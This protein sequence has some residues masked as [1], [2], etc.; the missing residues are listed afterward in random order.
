MAKNST[1]SKVLTYGIAAIVIYYVWKVYAPA[2]QAGIQKIT[3]GLGAATGAT[4]NPATTGT[5]PLP[6][7]NTTAGGLA[8]L[9][10]QLI[11]AANATQAQRDAIAQIN[12]QSVALAQERAAYGDSLT[13]LH[14]KI[15]L[16]M[17]SAT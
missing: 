5:T 11:P 12:A 2:I 8:G 17:G 15:A 1:A 13:S 6:G 14:S 16:Y 9:A 4:A 3:G 10:S 7:A